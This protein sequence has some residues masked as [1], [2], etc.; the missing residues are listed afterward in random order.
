MSNTQ[1]QDVRKVGRPRKSIEGR[2]Q[3]FAV[4]LSDDEIRAADAKAKALKI[5]RQEL[6]RRALHA[7]VP[8][9]AEV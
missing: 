6:G 5:G 3:V 9:I 7:L 8:K 1:K 4:R 2:A